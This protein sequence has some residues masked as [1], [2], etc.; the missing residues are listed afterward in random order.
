MVRH[1]L[2]KPITAYTEAWLE[3]RAVSVDN[4]HVDLK[5]ELW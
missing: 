1:T 2:P 5:T 4:Y 3:Y